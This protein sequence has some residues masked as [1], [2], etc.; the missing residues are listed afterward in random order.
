MRDAPLL[1]LDE[2]TAHL[3]AITAAEILA[4]V[5][6][7]MAHRTVVLVSHGPG[8]AARPARRSPC[9]TAACPRWRRHEL[10]AWQR[11]RRDPLVRV[12]WLAR[13][14]RGRLILA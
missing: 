4:T 1:L 14:L 6:T 9:T 8:W 11:A 5:E 2:P 10:A 3:D 12:L 13:P 7:L